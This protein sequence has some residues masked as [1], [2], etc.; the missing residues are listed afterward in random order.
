MRRVDTSTQPAECETQRAFLMF[1]RGLTQPPKIAALRSRRSAGGESIHLMVAAHLLR[2]W[3]RECIH[4]QRNKAPS[5]L[6]K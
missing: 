1:C 4:R 2:R 6:Q 5:N 3:G